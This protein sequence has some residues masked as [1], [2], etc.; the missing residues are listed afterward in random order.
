MFTK[1]KKS[2]FIYLVIESLPSPR[3][4]YCARPMPFG[5]RG[6]RESFVS[7]TSPIALTGKAWKDAV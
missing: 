2:Y 7:D 4:H 5:S 1:L 3:P 6:P